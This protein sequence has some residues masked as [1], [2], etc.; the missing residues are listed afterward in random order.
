MAFKDRL[1]PVLLPVPEAYRRLRGSEK[2]RFLRSH[3]RHAL[4]LSAKESG[5][6]LETI[7]KAENG[8]PIPLEGIFWSLSHKDTFVGAVAAPE[9]VG[10]DLE[11]IRS[12][13]EALF[14]RI[15]DERERGLTP[16][17]PTF[18]FFRYWTAKEAVL[19]AAGDGLSGLSRCRI[20]AVLDEKRL[21]VDYR[22]T[23]W[24]VMHHCFQGHMASLACG[25]FSIDWILP[26]EASCVS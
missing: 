6:R 19:K 8:A 5:V 4:M 1:Y 13:S 15:A 18:L 25:R 10:I 2:V 23:T 20:K 11:R 9:P 7:E 3:A 24:N 16:E 14:N 22:G 17:D 26:E 21:T 12:R